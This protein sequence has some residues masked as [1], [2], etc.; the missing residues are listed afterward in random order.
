[1]TKLK[2]FKKY[3]YFGNLREK[4]KIEEAITGYKSLMKEAEKKLFA[5][6]PEMIA[7]SYRMLKKPKLGLNFARQALQWAKKSKNKEMEANIRR[8][9]GGIYSDMN[10]IEKAERQY[11]KSLELMWSELSSKINGLAATFAFMAKLFVKK[12]DHKRA[13]KLIDTAISLTYPSVLFEPKEAGQYYWFVIYKAEH[14]KIQN[15]N[16]ESKEL[17]KYAL[18]G[19]KKLSQYQKV[20]INRAKKLLA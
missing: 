6:V 1:M 2:L 3:Q 16:R 11:A 7:V 8:D 12:K 4:G 18:S 17:A 20:R 10:E 14:Y 5:E 9:L 15:R 19:F 13:E